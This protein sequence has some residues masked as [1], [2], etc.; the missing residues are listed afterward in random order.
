MNRTL[1]FPFISRLTIKCKVSQRK[2]PRPKRQ[3][4]ALLHI[5]GSYPVLGLSFSGF[6]QSGCALT[7]LNANAFTLDKQTSIVIDYFNFKLEKNNWGLSRNYSTH[8]TRNDRAS[9]HGGVCFFSIFCTVGPRHDHVS[10]P[11][12]ARVTI[13]IKMRPDLGPMHSV[14]RPPSPRLKPP[15]TTTFEYVVAWMEMIQYISDHSIILW[16]SCRRSI[17]RHV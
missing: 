17:T 15:K 12:L 3:K 5:I 16:L 11:R 9:H 14:G 7:W 10:G 8:Q 6:N 13:P 4:S 2:S 1:C